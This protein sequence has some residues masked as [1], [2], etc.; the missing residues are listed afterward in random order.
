MPRDKGSQGT[1][2]TV[3]REAA[4]HLI[5]SMD[6]LRDRVQERRLAEQAFELLRQAAKLDEEEKKSE[7][8]AVV[9][10]IV[11]PIQRQVRSVVSGPLTNHHRG[12][13]GSPRH[14][15]CLA[16]LAARYAAVGPNTLV[17]PCVN[18]RGVRSV[19]RLWHH[20][21]SPLTDH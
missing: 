14:E 6:A 9:R 3:L 5:A 15:R 10:P 20:Q 21:N 17:A 11:N 12:G 13:D 4:R 16:I 2:A 7:P 18:L 19:G 1:A 8:S